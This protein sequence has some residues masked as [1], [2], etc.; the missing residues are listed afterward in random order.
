MV[1]EQSALAGVGLCMYNTVK[2]A[3]QCCPDSL[4]GCKIDSDHPQV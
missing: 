4:I 1:Y 3:V 2:I